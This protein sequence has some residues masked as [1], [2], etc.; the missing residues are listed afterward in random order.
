MI[1]CL[2][3]M[4]RIIQGGVTCLNKSFLSTELLKA[5]KTEL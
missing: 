1:Y 2:V 4:S 3:D 5:F